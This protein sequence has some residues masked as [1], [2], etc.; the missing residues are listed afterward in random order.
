MGEP[1]RE[2]IRQYTYADILTWPEG[3]RWELIDGMAYDMSPAPSRRHQELLGNIFMPFR[4]FLVD[5]PC[6]VYLAPFD[7][8]LPAAGETTMTTTTVVQPDLTVVCE[9]EKL[10][11]RGCVGSPTLVVEI[12]SP[13]TARKD[14]REK[15]RKYEGAGVLE[16][17][18]IYPAERML[19]VYLRDAEGRY[20]VPTVYLDGDQ[21]PVQTL[22]GLIIELGAV[23]AE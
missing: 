3:E 8:R 15:L 6:Q 7:V 18:V 22:P 12:L 9:P 21:V 17:W 5:S 13:Y 2:P 14:L 23:F 16:Y 11:D 19:Q 10:D 4:Q 1:A 20:D